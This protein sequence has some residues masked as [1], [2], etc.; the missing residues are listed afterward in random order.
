MTPRSRRLLLVAELVGV[1]LLGALLAVLVAGRVTTDAGPFRTDL[2]LHPSLDGG[3]QVAVPPLGTLELDTH[4][5]PVRLQVG[6][7]QLRPEAARSIADNP[8]QLARLGDEVS[9]DVRS[10]V[11]RLVLRTAVLTVLGSAALGLLVFRRRWRRTLVAVGAGVAA[12]G[13]VGA[14]TA[15]TTNP[16]ALAEPRFT[17]LLAS[18]PAA[19]GDVR[20]ILESFDAYGLQLGQLVTNVTQ[21]YDAS[22]SLPTFVPDDGAVRVLHVSD[23]HLSPTAF[24][25]IESVVEQFSIDL[26]VD[27]GDSTDHGTAVEDYYVDGVGRLDVPYAWVRGNHDSSDI[28]AAMRR[29]PNAVVLD[30]P[31]VVE[32]AGLRLMGQ[33][34]ARFTP[35]KT[36][37]DD[38]APTEVITAVGSALVEAYD[39]AADKP[40]LVLVHDPISARPLL[41][42]APLVL[43]GHSHERRVRT[44]DGTTLMV[45]GSTG[46]AGLRALEDEEPTPVMLTV[47]YLDAETGRLQAYDEL[48]LGGLGDT[49]ARISRRIGPSPSTPSPSP[50]GG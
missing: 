8:E 5:S 11:I 21:L 32:V 43:A 2:S 7:T 44:E 35:D 6:I 1:G 19:V 33:G 17:G 29:Q 47:L 42:T 40:H 3:T 12:L 10:G 26:V 31:D 25:V 45:Q 38:D 46:G 14:G 24:G 49:D 41:G 27:T 39:E 30:G 20:S 50:S 16:R 48:T 15:L 36:T 28:Q 18:A 9:A 22:S 4:D 37:R 23:L 13:L 34:D